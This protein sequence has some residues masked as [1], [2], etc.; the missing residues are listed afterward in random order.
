MFFNKEHLKSQ[1]GSEGHL[2]VIF[3]YI[4]MCVNQKA[5]TQDSH[6]L[7]CFLQT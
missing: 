4:L 6:Q 2:Y 5:Q 3:I 7:E 1:K